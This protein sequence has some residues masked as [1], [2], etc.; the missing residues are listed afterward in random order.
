MNAEPE[1]RLTDKSKDKLRTTKGDLRSRG[2]QLGQIEDL[3]SS[4]ENLMHKKEKQMS[5]GK[6]VEGRGEKRRSVK[7]MDSR[8][9]QESSGENQRSVVEKVDGRERDMGIV[10]RSGDLL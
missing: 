10:E 5:T 6:K 3:E 1:E 2:D 9:R 8:Q 4:D 7:K